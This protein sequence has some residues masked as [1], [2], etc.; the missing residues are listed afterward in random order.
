LPKVEWDEEALDDLEKIDRPIVK[1]I[2]HKITWFSQYFYSVTPALFSAS[3][4]LLLE[5][6]FASTFNL[7][8]KHLGC[9]NTGLKLFT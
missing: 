1:R 3:G 5:D 2:L 8:P 4:F 6:G 9:Y 7:R